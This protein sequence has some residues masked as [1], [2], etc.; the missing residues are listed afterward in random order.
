VA[1]FVLIV[2]VWIALPVFVYRTVN[3][4]SGSVLLSVVAAAVSVVV[5][6]VGLERAFRFGKAFLDERRSRR[7]SFS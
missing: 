2:V 1:S 5:A 3:A 6:A 4:A 7:G